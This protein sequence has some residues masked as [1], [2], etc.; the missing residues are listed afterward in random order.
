MMKIYALYKATGIVLKPLFLFS[1]QQAD[2]TSDV[3]Q[4]SQQSAAAPVST[5]EPAAPTET[6][7]DD[8]SEM[9]LLAQFG[10]PFQFGDTVGIWS[11]LPTC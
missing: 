5:E 3:P 10:L 11:Q 7:D 6:K 8:T 2:D 1:R 4:A 9:E